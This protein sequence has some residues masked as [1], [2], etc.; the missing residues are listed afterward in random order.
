MPGWEV[1]SVTL[2]RNMTGLR[3]HLM[4]EFRGSWDSDLQGRIA[5]QRV[6]LSQTL[7]HVGTS[8][9]FWSLEVLRTA[10]IADGRCTCFY[11]EAVVMNRTVAL[12]VCTASRCS[13]VSPGYRG[14]FA[15]EDLPTRMPLTYQI[16]TKPVWRNYRRAW[17]TESSL[18]STSSKYVDP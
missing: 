14:G 16:F 11:R 9:Y 5:P 7:T 8:C 10:V 6:Y 4:R 18:P 12:D 13:P 1:T 15:H 2:G 3:T 17:R